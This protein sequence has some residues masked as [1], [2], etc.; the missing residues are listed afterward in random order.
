VGVDIATMAGTVPKA[1]QLVS[2]SDSKKCLHEVE[3]N[4]E[5]I[6]NKS[7]SVGT[8]NEAVVKLVFDNDG[9][10]ACHSDVVGLYL[11]NH[12]VDQSVREMFGSADHSIMSS[13][14]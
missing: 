12:S 5:V 13:I 8:L 4:E 14:T 7:F 9:M 1:I 3:Y 2:N 11:V 10:V 6:F